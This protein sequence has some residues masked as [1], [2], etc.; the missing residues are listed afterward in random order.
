LGKGNMTMNKKLCIGLSFILVGSQGLNAME[1]AEK[2]EGAS[3]QITSAVAPLFEQEKITLPLIHDFLV[4]GVVPDIPADVGT[5]IA[6]HV[7]RNNLLLPWLVS[8]T[9]PNA[10]T[11]RHAKW[12][13]KVEFNKKGTKLVTTSGDTAEIWD[14]HTGILLHP[15]PHEN[16]RIAHFDPTGKNM[17]TVS[18]LAVKLWNA[19]DGTFRYELPHGERVFDAI[20]D[21]TGNKLFTMGEN[22]I[23]SWNVSTGELLHR[24]THDNK[25]YGI[26]FDAKQTKAVTV[27]HDRTAKLW[28]VETGKLLQIFSPGSYVTRVLIDRLGTKVI[29]VSPEGFTGIWDT[30]TGILLREFTKEWVTNAAL[31][32][33]ET[34]L[35]LAMSRGG[36]KLYDTASGERLHTFEAPGFVSF[37]K[38]NRTGDKI[39][40]LIEGYSIKIWDVSTGKVLKEISAQDANGIKLDLDETMILVWDVTDVKLWD[41]ATG[42]LLYTPT[43]DAQISDAAFN[44][45]GIRVAT[46]SQDG[47]AKL[48]DISIISYL[49]KQLTLEQVLLLSYI[50]AL[51]ILQKAP[52]ERVLFDFN[53]YPHLQKV[54][55]SLPSDIRKALTP[56]V[57]EKKT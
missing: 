31:N 22:I 33:E 23:T 20:F 7:M 38:F 56:Y 24:F 34:K 51:D 50:Y 32:R 6:Q 10:I 44:D 47:T 16:V 49:R 46:A 42:K 53:I 18:P 15:L 12:V 39:F 35:A 37:L 54:F 41:S 17:V 28:D 29:I 57:V 21:N 8:K 48:W 45:S 52:T 9:T 26:Q 27:S 14:V 36:V 40:A 4:R 3:S 13:W 43:H 1:K 5:V 55:D 11:L 19:E 30:A 25:I 2:Q